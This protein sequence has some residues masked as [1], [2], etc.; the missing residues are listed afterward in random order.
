MKITKHQLAEAVSQIA[1]STD[2]RVFWAG[3]DTARLV[4]TV[5][6]Q[7]WQ[8][9]AITLVQNEFG[10]VLQGGGEVIRCTPRKWVDIWGRRIEDVW[11]QAVDCAKGWLM[12][13]PGMTEVGHVPHP[14]LT[15][16]LR[17]SI[18][19]GVSADLQG[20]A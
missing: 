12:S 13:R 10:Q 11:N 6:W 3:F 17:R 5:Y 7:A 18:T 16:A 15:S 14:R 4:S 8:C 1:T 20:E 9:P 2:P 19:D